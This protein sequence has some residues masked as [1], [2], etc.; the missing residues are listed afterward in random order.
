[1]PGGRPSMQPKHYYSDIGRVTVSAE[2]VPVINGEGQP[3]AP[4]YRGILREVAT[5]G[6]DGRAHK[7]AESS[8]V[9]ETYEEAVSDGHEIAKA[10]GY[11]A[12]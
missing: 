6:S 10:R 12:G 5:D 9:R 11:R 2:E 8:S 4:R 3:A 1:G 7:I